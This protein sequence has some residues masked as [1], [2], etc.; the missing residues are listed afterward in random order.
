MLPESEGMERVTP[1][2]QQSKYFLIFREWAKISCVPMDYFW[3][4]LLVMT[5]QCG[6]NE[7]GEFGGILQIWL[8]D[9]I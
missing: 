8:I 3:K 7:A 4:L 1:F 6:V 2:R 5:T 9:C